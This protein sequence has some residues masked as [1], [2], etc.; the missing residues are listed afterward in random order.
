VTQDEFAPD[1]TLDLAEFGE[2]EAYFRVG[3]Y[4]YRMLQIGGIIGI[5]AG[6]GMLGLVVGLALLGGRGPMG[7]AWSALLHGAIFALTALAAGVAALARSRHYRGLQVLVCSRGLLCLREERIEQV[8]WPSIR[9]VQR[10][11]KPSESISSS[12]EPRSQLVL[13]RVDDSKIVFDETLHDLPRLRELIE[14]H[15]LDHLLA[16]VL[17]TM[18]GGESVAFGPARVSEESL[19][20]E[21]AVLPWSRYGHA[22]VES[23]QVT[24]YEADGKSFCKL[25]T[26]TTPNSHV[27]LA[28]AEFFG[29][30]DKPTSLSEDLSS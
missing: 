6:V 4:H 28:L 12:W 26:A 2:P 1:A 9:S 17:E 5:V 8:P 24:I 30:S 10:V 11:P 21:K 23:R 27:L 7:R 25:D 29:D 19:V 18:R 20:F 13:E 22:V 16:L 3:G 15:T 14:E